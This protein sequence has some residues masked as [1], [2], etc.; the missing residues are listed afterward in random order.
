MAYQLVVPKRVQKQIDNIAQKDCA[1]II[2]ALQVIALDPFSGKKLYGRHSGQWSYRVWSYRII[3]EIRKRE[4]IILVISVG[5]RQ[6]VY[7]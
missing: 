4:L 1:R 5:Q 6:G 3:Y 7:K 2:S